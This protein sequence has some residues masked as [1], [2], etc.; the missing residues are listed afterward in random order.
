MSEFTADETPVPSV[1][2]NQKTIFYGTGA[3]IATL[4]TYPF[5]IACCTASGSGFTVNTV[6]QRDANSAGWVVMGYLSA[7]TG[8]I[9]YWGGS[10]WNR[11]PVGSNGQ[12]LTVAGGLPTWGTPT[13]GGSPH[14]LLDGNINQDTTPGFPS[15]GALVKGNGATWQSLPITGVPPGW[16]LTAS[17]GGDAIWFP[18]TG[19]GGGGYA[20][21]L[22]SQTGTINGGLHTSSTTGSTQCLGAGGQY[23]TTKSGKVT[24]TCDVTSLWGNTQGYASINLAVG[25]GTYPGRGFAPTNVVR[26]SLSHFLEAESEVFPSSVTAFA[27]AMGETITLLASLAQGTTHWIDIIGNIAVS[28]IGSLASPTYN[29]NTGLIYILEF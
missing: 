25:T 6:Y 9:M 11:L 14:P 16:V 22:F 19:G 13:S 26:T 23:S 2:L 15:L 4:V 5:K 29:F 24:I 7:T 8:D 1:Q 28:N 20:G 17:G 10:L 27:F 18:S 21:P 12:V 3:Q